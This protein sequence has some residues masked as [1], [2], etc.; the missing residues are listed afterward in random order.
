MGSQSHAKFQYNR[1]SRYRETAGGKFVTPSGRHAPRATV[2]TGTILHWSH[3]RKK[4]WGYPPKKTACQS[5]FR[6]QRYKSIKSVTTAG[7]PVAHTQDFPLFSVELARPSASLVKSKNVIPPSPLPCICHCVICC[8]SRIFADSNKF[9]QEYL[10]FV[11]CQTIH[12]PQYSLDNELEDN[13]GIINF[14]WI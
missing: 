7:R 5:G 6:F 2:G 9:S 1:P 13:V 12:F 3:T 14:S 10:V 11:T 8:A 4:G